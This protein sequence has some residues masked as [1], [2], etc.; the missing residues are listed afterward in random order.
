MKTFKLLFFSLSLSLF[1]SCDNDDDTTTP[2]DQD[3]LIGS[4]EM[5][6][7]NVDTDF[8]GTLLDVPITSS[9]NSIGENFDYVLTFTETTYN[10]SGSYDVVT[11]GT[12]NGVPLDEE[13]ETVTDADESGTYEFIDGELVIDGALIDLDEVNSELEGIE[14]DPNFEA[15]LNSN[16]ELV[17]EQSGEITIDA[18]GTPL[19]I[20]YDSRLV[21][22]KQ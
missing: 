7:L 21:F 19:D 13:R 22:R 3:T 15:T 6:S 2:V 9:T 11:T 4:W 14:I 12:V 20:E 5:I 1:I 17:I 16:G 8:S 18:E 10:A